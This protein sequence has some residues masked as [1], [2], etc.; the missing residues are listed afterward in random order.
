MTMPK[1]VYFNFKNLFIKGAF[2]N[3]NIFVDYQQHLI[4]AAS[5]WV[6]YE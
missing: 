1:V 4:Q 6:K 2:Q 3:I 5:A